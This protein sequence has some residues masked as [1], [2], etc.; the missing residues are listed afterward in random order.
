M[1]SSSTTRK[2]A[3]RK[4]C[5]NFW[6]RRPTAPASATSS[7]RRR[8]RSKAPPLGLFARVSWT[9]GL[10]TPSPRVRGE[11]RDE[12]LSCVSSVLPWPVVSEN[13]VEDGQKLS[14]DGDE[15][16]HLGLASCHET[17]E[18]DFQGWVVLLGDH[19]AHEHG[20]AGHCS[21]TADEAAPPPLARLAREWGEAGEGCNFLAAELPE[22]GQLGHQ[23]AGDDLSDARHGGEQ[24]L[25]LSPGW[26]APYGVV[27]IYIDTAQF[28]L[29]RLEKPCDALLEAWRRHSSLALAFGHHHFNDL[30]SA[31]RKIGQQACCLVRQ[32]ARLGLCR[33]GKMRDDGSIDRVGLGTLSASLGE[34]PDISRVDHH[35]R[36]SRRGQYCR[37]YGFEAAGGLQGDN[38]R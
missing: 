15:C 11:G 6:T 33:L 18:E 34:G 36:K 26:R 23:G 31:R 35:H 17:I 25:L 1:P 12:R 27:D 30:P 10:S 20:R 8:P 21:A 9:H 7:A 19:R 22:L 37:Y 16:D 2:T 4:A 28:L 29:Q 38:V 5:A 24:V 13:S 14:G 3:A 32:G